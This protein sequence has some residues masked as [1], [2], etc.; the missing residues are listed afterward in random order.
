MTQAEAALKFAR[1]DAARYRDLAEKGAG[2][3]QRSQSSAST[4]DQQQAA[5]TARKATR[6]RGAQPGRLARGAEG[7]RRGQPRQPARP[8]VARPNS[9]SATPP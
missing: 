5:S 1:E 8:S 9:I 2:T 7:G 6:R 3:I 4:L